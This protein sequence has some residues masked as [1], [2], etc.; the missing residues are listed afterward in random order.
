MRSPNY[1][2]R[3]DD[4]EVV[5]AIVAGEPAGLA[6][7]YDRYA[8]ALYTYC[9]S[10]LRE[11]ADAADAVQDTFVIAASKVAGLRDP[12]RLR[13][14]LYAVARNECQRRLRGREVAGLDEAMLA[15]TETTTSLHAVDA[16]LDVGD[17]TERTELRK[18]VRDAIGGLNPGEQEVIELSLRH[19]LDGTELADALGVSRNHA[20]AL[21]SRART[22]LEKSLGVLLVARTARHACPELDAML[23]DWDGTLTVLL[24]KRVSRHI[25]RCEICSEH[26]RR[27]LR[28]AMLLGLLPLAMLPTG[29]WEQTLR[30]AADSTPEAMAHRASIAQR[31]G[32]F[33]E[34][35]FPAP[36]NPPR[37]VGWRAHKVPIQA[38]MVTGA[39]A[40]IAVVAVL[41]LSGTPHSPASV[42]GS[43]RGPAGAGPG[44]ASRSAAPSPVPGAGATATAAAGTGAGGPG[45]GAGAGAS[46]SVTGTGTA[47]AGG[48]SSKTSPASGS[49]SGSASASTS[50]ST[51]AP[52]T[53]GTLSV[54]P[55]TLVLTATVGGGT[56][57]LDPNCPEWP[58]IPVHNHRRRN[59]RRQA[60]GLAVHG[61]TGLRPE[62]EDH[63]DQ[64]S[65][66]R[67]HPAHDQPRRPFRNSAAR[68]RPHRQP[69]PLTCGPAPAKAHLSPK[70]IVLTASSSPSAT[71]RVAR[72]A[73]NQPGTSRRKTP[74]EPSCAGPLRARAI[75]AAQDSPPTA[76]AGHRRSLPSA[77]ARPSRAG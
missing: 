16:P 34:N 76:P 4:R 15:D 17:D 71:G 25:E 14:W 44:G 72:H 19:E 65:P 20:H 58:H 74:P 39:A 29:F 68:R 63:S 61:I 38:A 46:R 41:T 12:S 59:R 48:A 6:Q 52:V 7:A 2:R 57:T 28:P 73:P 18:L 64:H 5:A 54:T 30:L 62:R 9:R 21:L 3:M 13:P 11:S 10:L 47:P 45:A 24:R 55:S 33:G 60:D 69:P 26:K 43:G 42:A 66:I 75:S 23:S 37:P 40:A 67:R 53:Q 56:G 36:L 70:R 27:E 31:A 35:G 1:R 32:P 8:A 22:Q 51:S 49:T 77:P 50:T